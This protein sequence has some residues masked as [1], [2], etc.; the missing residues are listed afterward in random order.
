MSENNV[1]VLLLT[2]VWA[3]ENNV[4]LEVWICEYLLFQGLT[5]LIC[6]MKTSI[7][8]FQGCSE[9]LDETIVFKCLT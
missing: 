4:A 2:I 9:G 8:I 3:E 6:S 7:F 5:S 1:L